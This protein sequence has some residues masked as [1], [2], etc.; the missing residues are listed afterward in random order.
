ML[1]AH[2]RNCTYGSPT[3][4]TSVNQALYVGIKIIADRSAVLIRLMRLSLH[5]FHPASCA[6]SL[7]V[8]RFI[9]LLNLIC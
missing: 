5:D 8:F 4:S 7:M 1:T 6:L 2:H 3:L 9:D